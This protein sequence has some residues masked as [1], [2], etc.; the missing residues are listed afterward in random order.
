MR[1][2]IWWLYFALH[3][4]KIV[5]FNVN[6]V[7]FIKLCANKI[8]LALRI[9]NK[10]KRF[11]NTTIWG[12]KRQRFS[13]T[14]SLLLSILS[15]ATYANNTAFEE[16]TN[17]LPSEILSYPFQIDNELFD[18]A[19]Q[20]V[21]K[22][23]VSG[24]LSTA[25]LLL[26][27]AIDNTDF[28]KHPRTLISRLLVR[29]QLDSKAGANISALQD[30]QF[31]FRLAASTN[32]QD[33]VADIAYNIANIHQSR[34]EHSIALSYV[35]QALDKY[36][37]LGAKNKVIASQLLATSSLLA[38]NQNDKALLNLAELKDDIIASNDASVRSRYFQYL[39]EAQLNTSQYQKSIYNLKFAT[40]IAS[41][42]DFTQLATLNLLLSRAYTSIDNMNLAI[43]HLVKAF[44]IANKAHSSF[45]LNQALQLHRADLLGQLNEFEAAFKL[46]QTVLKDRDLHQPV[47]E[48]K[49][50]LDMH[51]NFQL[52]LQ[53][54]ENIE[55]KQENH[56]K[57]AQIESKQMLNRLY[58]IVIA[59]LVCVS[60]LLLLLF[61]RGRKHRISLEQIAHTDALTGLYSRTRVL[62]LLNHHQNLSARISKPF[63][64]A[65]VDLDFFK[66]INDT[67]GHP[68]GDRVLKAFGELCLSN[69]RKSDMC[70]RI[71]G[72]E[73]LI[74]LPNTSIKEACDVFE[75]LNE[76]LPSIGNQLGLTLSTT[77]S[78][79]LVSPQ[80]NEA[81]MDIV[82]RADEALYAAKEQ[83]RNRV[84]VGEY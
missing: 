22:M 11:L 34:N 45:Y 43:D 59:L 44:S 6:T 19:D 30:L 3:Y 61:L 76:K 58:F 7:Y 15:V 62:D 41:D 65:I 20:Q 4:A 79:G 52:E 36:L 57:N 46:T 82:R 17:H 24:E 56:W 84:V 8:T 78:I 35:H 14:I 1:E 48:I 60:S 33:L 51:A 26:N 47:S 25:R 54:Q 55:L 69:F 10:R 31:A 37:L 72:E 16:F 23:I 39:G 75:A 40:S 64:V 5:G 9:T 42:K 29:A 66:N 21:Q 80:P 49:R 81:L 63:C 13:F 28:G 50:M 12:S 68:V 38:S 73:F 27:Q 2:I 77:A 70:G 67:Y 83:G 71:G 53:Q 32:Q 18:D 74:I